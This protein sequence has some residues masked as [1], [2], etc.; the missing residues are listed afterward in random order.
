M[1][2]RIVFSGSEVVEGEDA[3]FTESFEFVEESK[4]PLLPKRMSR[5]L[6]NPVAKVFDPNTKRAVVA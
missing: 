4:R 2:H 3:I 6:L 1:P 5:L